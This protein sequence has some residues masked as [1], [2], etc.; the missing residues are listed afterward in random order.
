MIKQYMAG[1]W[2]KQIS[3]TTDK[4]LYSKDLKNLTVI[5]GKKEKKK[6]R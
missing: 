5:R 1:W 2:W 3:E 4:H 6:N